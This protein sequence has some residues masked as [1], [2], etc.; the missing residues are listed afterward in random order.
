MNENLNIGAIDADL[1]IETKLKEEDI[2]FHDVKNSPFDVY[3]FE[4]SYKPMKFLRLPAEFGETAN[5]GVTT[6]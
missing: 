2:V 1:K 6:L 5:T 4:P 3:G